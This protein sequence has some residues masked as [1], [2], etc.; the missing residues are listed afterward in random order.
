LPV[1]QKPPHF[2]CGGFLYESADTKKIFHLESVGSIII[3]YSY[4]FF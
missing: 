4:I 3:M 2:T 1:R